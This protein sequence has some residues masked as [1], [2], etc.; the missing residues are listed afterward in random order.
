MKGKMVLLE[1]FAMSFFS[2]LKPFLYGTQGSRLVLKIRIW[3][4][5]EY[6]SGSET[7]PVGGKYQC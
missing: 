6:G 7:L 3:I 1:G 2:K 4:H 5:S